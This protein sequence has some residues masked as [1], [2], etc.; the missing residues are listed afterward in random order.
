MIQK[1]LHLS[2]LLSL[3]LVAK[4]YKKQPETFFKKKRAYNDK[5]LR[6]AQAEPIMDSAYTYTWNPATSAY[7]TTM[8]IILP[9]LESDD[10]HPYIE[11]TI[12]KGIKYNFEKVETSH[13]VEGILKNMISYTWDPIQETWEKDYEVTLEYDK[14]KRMSEEIYYSNEERYKNEYWYNAQGILDTVYYSSWNPST[15]TW[16]Y[17]VKEVFKINDQGLETS[18]VSY[19][20]IDLASSWWPSSK[21]ELSYNS[22][23]DVILSNEYDRDSENTTWLYLSQ[24]K[25]FYDNQGND[26]LVI[27]SNWD[28]QL[29]TFIPAVKHEYSMETHSMFIKTYDFNAVSQTWKNSQ[30]SEIYFHRDPV[31]VS[32][33]VLKSQFDVY[34]NPTVDKIIVNGSH[35]L[36]YTIYDLL[37]NEVL[38][39]NTPE[40]N[41]TQLPKGTYMLKIVTEKGTQSKSF[42]KN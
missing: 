11:Y 38:S 28:D 12:V 5:A 13:N 18:H 42:I 31:A 25:F 15:S 20:W 32:D 2:L 33:Q 17:G 23:G 37:G 35:A 10:M 9:H 26:S 40:I 34:P 7:D 16:E 22:N 6:V 24:D 29:Q 8:F 14:G 19:L 41:V 3:S 1:L 39:V 27:S 30:I 36:Q 4:D 21:T